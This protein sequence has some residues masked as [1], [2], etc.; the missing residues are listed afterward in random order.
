MQAMHCFRLWLSLTQGRIRGIGC[1]LH[2]SKAS[3]KG[4]AMQLKVTTPVLAL[5]AGQV[6]TLDDA[7]GL[8]ILARGGTVWVTEEGDPKD[9]I[10]R[11]GDTLTVARPGRTVIQALQAAWISI[12]E[13]LCAANDATLEPQS[14]H[15]SAEDFLDEVRSRIYSRYY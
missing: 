3:I 8:R 9:H 5:E 1:I 2:A 6:V 14:P 7:E 10:V 11:P 15:R 4:G 13:G 12:S